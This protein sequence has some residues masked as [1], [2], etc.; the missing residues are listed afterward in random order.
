MAFTENKLF[1]SRK[2][3][4]PLHLVS[5]LNGAVPVIGQVTGMEDKWKCT[6]AL[7]AAIPAYGNLERLRKKLS[8]IEASSPE[9]TS[10]IN[11]LKD[12]KNTVELFER[13][14]GNAK[15]GAS[16]LSHDRKIK[17][18]AYLQDI[19]TSP[20]ITSLKNKQRKAKRIT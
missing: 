1:F 9:R 3:K 19:I 2:H 16:G 7:L 13:L 18:N 20:K 4:E 11:A 6:G 12:A 15:T 17:N 14:Y 10:D 5:A 8:I